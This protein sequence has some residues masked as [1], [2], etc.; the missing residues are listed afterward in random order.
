MPRSFL[1]KTVSKKIVNGSNAFASKTS[2]TSDGSPIS[3]STPTLNNYCDV[4]TEADSERECPRP[5]L[6]SVPATPKSFSPSSASAFTAVTPKN[7]EISRQYGEFGHFE[8]CENPA[9]PMMRDENL[10]KNTESAA[11]S[12]GLSIDVQK[13]PCEISTYTVPS[14][15]PNGFNKAMIEL[16]KDGKLSYTDVYRAQFAHAEKQILKAF[17]TEQ[18]YWTNNQISAFADDMDDID[19]GMDFKDDFESEKSLM[20][21][22]GSFSCVK[23]K[24]VFST[25]HGLE[26]HVRRSHSG[27]R[28]YACEICNKTFGHAVSLSQHMAVHTQ[29]RSFQCKQ[30]GKRFKR[31]STL[32]T[33]LL[34]HS[35]TRPYPCQYCGKRFHQKSDMKKH[36]YIHTGEKPYKCLKCGKAFSQSSN[37]ITHSRKHT[38]YKPFSCQICTKAFQR[39]VDLR[40]HH[41]TQHASTERQ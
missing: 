34:I 5:E 28:P 20:S 41:E 39:K 11:M 12:A 24:K 36:T 4:K 25:P 9:V 26:V 17:T 7:Q 30:C 1:V 13:W 16:L 3:P 15:P 23:C 35:D 6:Q 33:H 37:L 38:G 27:K 32:S 22:T 10:Y 2:A 18:L 40:R 8:R 29:E 31:S 14:P 21:I 19:D